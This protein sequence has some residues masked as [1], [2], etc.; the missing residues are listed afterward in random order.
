MAIASLG[1]P[2]SRA[3][4]ALTADHSSLDSSQESILDSELVART[5]G[6]AQPLSRWMGWRLRLLVGAALLGC[7]AVLM[8]ARWLAKAPQL[9]AQW[10]ANAMGQ[11]E[12][13]QSPD[14]R[15][16]PFVGRVLVGS[17]KADGSVALVDALA[18]RRS[19]RWITHDIDRQRF[20]SMQERLSG[21]LSQH[22]A[23]LVFDNGQVVETHIAP[24]ALSGL[25]AMFWLLSFLALALYM[26][27]MAVLLARPSV[28]NLL[29][30][31]IAACQAGTLGFMAVESTTL[32]V[33]PLPFTT[34][35]LS[36]RMALD[37]ITV[38]A[39]VHTA[40]MHPR[41]LP[42]ASAIAWLGWAGMLTLLVFLSSGWLLGTWWWMQ[43]TM[44]LMGSVAMGLLT[45]SYRLEPHPSAL[46]L[47]RF[48]LIA[49]STLSVL[50]VALI[51]SERAPGIHQ[52]IASAGPM[53]WY[54]LLSS[55]LLLMPYLSKSQQVMR[56]FS[57]VAAISTLATTLDL[58]FIAVFSLGQFT[59]LTLAL[60]LSLGLYSGSRQWLLTRLRHENVLTTERMFEKLYRIAREVEAH[61]ER[62]STLLLQLLRELFVPLEA[63]VVDKSSQATRVL[64]NGST[65]VV[66]IPNVT[67]H[68]DAGQH[69][70]VIRF[71]H[72]GHRLFTSE[73]A[74]LAERVVEQ[75]R[76][77]VAFDNAVEQ[78][79][80][81]E[82]L[83]LAQDLHDDIGARLLTLMYKAQSPEMEDYARHTLQDLKTLTRGLA[84]S[85]H[86]LSHAA[87]E[88][89]ADLTQR[90]TAAQVSL[91]WSFSTDREVTL[92]VVQ[93]SAL[94]R[95]LR[96]LVSNVIAHSLA[97]RVEIDFQLENDRLDL[98]VT[99]N[100]NGRNPQ[101]WSHGLGLGGVRKRVK[102]LGGEVEWQ[103]A[104]SGGI[105]CHVCIRQLSERA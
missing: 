95:V 48:V 15:L 59:S 78:G 25:G 5:L 30:A 80:N 69:S 92:N 102:Q 24:L 83:R 51:A 4:G 61:P 101:A 7:L 90:L 49:I 18:L 57:L 91:G 60:F 29:Y 42:G 47:R 44:V 22:A 23:Q 21:L 2:A 71:A 52:Q 105:V 103:E 17:L 37:L 82:R 85:S 39:V 75:L 33:L 81:E 66:P 43:G 96:E 87:A 84:A 58:I 34:W 10:R 76:R 19:P 26:V 11:I 54:I 63:A 36:M 27:A 20:I 79:R 31:A 94:T 77:A 70:I 53:T 64:G 3:S 13:V 46:V 14:P 68:E 74:R 35:N 99:D 1:A 38:G 55:L 56:E 50:S 28:R 93:W 86:P 12:L 45:W 6:D 62:T 32:L 89:K 104:P 41:R 16:K 72:R 88:W 100:G 9:D 40:A 8:T 98:S 73:D 65:L 97:R 67:P